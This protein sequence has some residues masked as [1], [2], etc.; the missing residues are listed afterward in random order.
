MENSIP[1]LIYRMTHDDSGLVSATLDH[2]VTDCSKS[3]PSSQCLPC[4]WIY[5]YPTIFVG[6]LDHNL[7]LQTLEKI[8]DSLE[9][10]K[11][12]LFF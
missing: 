4:F 8:E 11:K 7:F 3:V 10:R 1:I 2:E 5:Y 9:Q 12:Y 6:F